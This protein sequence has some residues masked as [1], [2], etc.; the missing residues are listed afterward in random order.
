MAKYLDET[1][2]STLVS[3]IKSNFAPIEDGQIPAEYIPS[4][5]LEK[6]V[7]PFNGFVAGV[8][9]TSAGSTVNGVVYDTTAKTFY[10]YTEDLTQKRTYYTWFTD[11]ENYVTSD[12][13]D[14]PTPLSNKIFIDTTTNTL[15]SYINSELVKVAASE[16]DIEALSN[17]LVYKGTLGTGGTVTALPDSA[18]IGDVYVCSTSG[19][20]QICVLEGGNKTATELEVGDMCICKSLKGGTSSTKS[21]WTIVQNNLT[22]AV[23]SSSTLTA[24]YLI[25]GNGG[26]TVKALAPSTGYLSWSGSA[27]SWV[28]PESYALPAATTSNLGGVKVDQASGK[29]LTELSISQATET[30]KITPKYSTFAGATGQSATSID[31]M[32]SSTKAGMISGTYIQ[33]LIGIDPG[34]TKTIIDT[35]A[36]SGSTN[37]AQSGDVYTK[38][39]E[40]N[41]A[42]SAFTPISD[43]TINALFA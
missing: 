15:Y 39:T 42:I 41:N 37:A 40:L 35:T 14:T 7:R 26:K 12:D 19:T 23:T 43:S 32:A 5:A 8:T 3:N 10:G 30:F 9:V 33:K 21:C 27:Y 13:E 24:N 2:L 18:E 4:G 16:S 36:Q 22:G 11:A 20:Y 28:S 25:L 34:A 31:M 38:Y 6:E 1:G 17:A 29:F